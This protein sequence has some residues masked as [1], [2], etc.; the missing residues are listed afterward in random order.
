MV[1]VLD[2]E[3]AGSSYPRADLVE[4]RRDFIPEDPT[5]DGGAFIYDPASGRRVKPE[6]VARVIRRYTK[7]KLLDYE[8]QFVGSV[9]ARFRDLIEEIEPGVHQFL[10]LRVIGK[11][12]ELLEDRW[13]WIICNRLDSV[14]RERSTGELDRRVYGARKG[15]P[16]RLVFS[17]EAI[18]RAKFWRDKHY[19]IGRLATDEVK[20]RLVAERITGVRFIHQEQA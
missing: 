19:S 16:F 7:R 13:T 9:S 12:D 10:P 17:L 6:S 14:D 18:G 11:D 15:V 3:P 5:P 20:E 8:N 2:Y 1:Y 4:G